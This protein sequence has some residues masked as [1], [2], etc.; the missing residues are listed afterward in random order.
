VPLYPRCR[1]GEP[2]T[3]DSPIPVALH[4]HMGMKRGRA[5][6]VVPLLMVRMPWGA[7]PL[8]KWAPVVMPVFEP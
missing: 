7:K 3:R 8:G 1:H 2:S 6:N 4:P 5:R